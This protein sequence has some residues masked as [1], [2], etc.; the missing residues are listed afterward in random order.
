MNKLLTTIILLCFSVAANAQETTSLNCVGEMT[1]GDNNVDTNDGIPVILETSLS[2]EKSI[3]IMG[4]TYEV[5]ETP[6]EYNVDPFKNV[7]QVGLSL[8]RHTLSLIWIYPKYRGQDTM[9]FEANCSLLGE[10]KI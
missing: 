3:T 9:L 7:S 2:G 8:N 6:A 10:P 1:L 5:E 4:R